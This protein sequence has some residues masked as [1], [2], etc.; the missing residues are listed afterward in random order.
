MLS[1]LAISL[2]WAAAGDITGTIMLKGTPPPEKKI[3]KGS[4]PKCGSAEDTTHHYVVGSKGEFANV[5]VYLEGPGVAGTSKGGTAE[6]AL[7]DQK[8]CEYSPVIFAVQTGQKIMIKNSDQ[9]LHN[10]HSVPSE[11][12]GNKTINQAQMAG[13]PELAYAP[14]KPE[15]FLKFQCDVHPW[16]FS[17]VC[18]FDHPYFAVTDKDG[19]FKIANVPAGK[20]KI[21]ASHRKAGDATQDVEVTEGAAAKV[22]FA[23]EAK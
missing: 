6:P 2:Q 22:D 13:G 8:G 3:D 21:T 5:V 18:I 9:T 23:L 7:L 16:M 15:K 20:Y 4:D 19:N 1:A 10:V 14:A 11:S 12:S 17:W